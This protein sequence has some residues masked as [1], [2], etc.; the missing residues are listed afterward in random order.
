[1][2]MQK[3]KKNNSG[4][5]RIGS[6]KIADDVVAMIAALAALEV[7]GVS[8]MAGGIGSEAVGRVSRSRLSR[9]V[10]VAVS[11]SHARVDMSVM[12]E[13]GVN[14]PATCGKVQKRVKTAIENMTGLRV[15]TVN[16]RIAQ[17]TM[18]GEQESGQ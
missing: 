2:E 5:G 13:Y 1:M 10:R 11:Q 6:V 7:D 12:L 4:R 15:P 17:I 16:V 18:P 8:A 14:I 9:C 3:D